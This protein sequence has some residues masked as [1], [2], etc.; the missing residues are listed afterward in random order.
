MSCN[1]LGN[2]SSI[3]AKQ[4]CK[5]VAGIACRICTLLFAFFA[6]SGFLK[7]NLLITGHLLSVQ[8]ACISMYG[9][10]AVLTGIQR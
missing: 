2:F 9:L 6:L 3:K 4:L 1:S 10:I 7:Q 8:K 5:T